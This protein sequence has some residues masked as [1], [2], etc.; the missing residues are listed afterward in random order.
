MNVSSPF[1]VLANILSHRGRTH[2][3]LI[4][5]GALYV[6]GIHTPMVLVHALLCILIFA[7]RP[8]SGAMMRVHAWLV[9]VCHLISTHTCITYAL[10][11]HG[12]LSHVCC[13]GQR[14][15]SR[16]S[17]IMLSSLNITSNSSTSDMNNRRLLSAS[18]P[19]PSVSLHDTPPFSPP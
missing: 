17:W 9:E 7:C 5:R 15:R 11:R 12:L 4:S 2:A 8:F 6:T 1:F 19:A 3:D 18:N 14:G 16:K 10:C 13:L